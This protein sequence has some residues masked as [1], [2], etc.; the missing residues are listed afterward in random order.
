VT[1]TDYVIN[2]ILVLL[3]LRQIRGSRLDLFNLVLPVVLVATAAAY[4][5]HSVPTAGNDIALD[6]MLAAAGAILGALCAMATRLS[7]GPGGK[8]LA[9]A[10]A[11]AVVLWVAG[12]GARMAFAFASD[13][14]AGPA[15]GR[16]SLAH[17]ITSASA[18]EAAL[19]M[20]ALSEVI[21][22][23]AVLRLRARR[24]PRPVSELVASPAALVEVSS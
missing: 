22:R 3:V 9:K 23:L 21:T 6:V 14:G 20:M 10:G 16:F 11:A 18:W 4:F 7:R 1:A 24:L 5:L 19:V 2:A 12:I 13:H 17:D 8:V 15:I